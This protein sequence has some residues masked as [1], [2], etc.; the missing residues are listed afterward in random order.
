[1]ALR[2]SSIQ[3]SSL[4][5]SFQGRKPTQICKDAVNKACRLNPGDGLVWVKGAVLVSCE[6]P[7]VSKSKGY[8]PALSFPEGRGE[9]RE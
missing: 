9:V 4:A 7:T 8:L 1:M 5:V 2:D 3:I 6:D